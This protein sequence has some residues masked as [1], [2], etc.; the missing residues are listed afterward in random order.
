M[1]FTR[2]V[3]NVEL[4]RVR[5][6]HDGASEAL[7]TQQIPKVHLTWAWL[8]LEGAIL[9]T[10]DLACVFWHY[11][12]LLRACSDTGH[13]FDF[14]RCDCDRDRDIDTETQADRATE[15]QTEIVACDF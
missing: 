5:V 6:D 10:W 7:Q 14:C 4:R 1:E 8:L 15:A 3:E 12:D 13:H 2:F 11:F 9:V